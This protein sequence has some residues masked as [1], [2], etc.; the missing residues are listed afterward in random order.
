M[1]NSEN[2]TL[3]TLVLGL[4]LYKVR[5]Y[6]EY[7]ISVV[8]AL[9]HPYSTRNNLFLVSNYFQDLSLSH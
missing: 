9:P 7:T 4:M 2:L 1:T 8:N 5:V 3:D 6:T